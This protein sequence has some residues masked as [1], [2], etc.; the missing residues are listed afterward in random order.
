VIDCCVGLGSNLGDRMGMLT[1]AVERL[2]LEE[3]FALRG[4]SR[5]YETEPVGPPQ[6]RFLNLCVKLGS[7]VS[8]RATLQKLLAIE[9]KLGRV[10]RERWGPREID[11]D[12]LFYGALVS[13]AHGLVPAPHA[14]QIPHPRLHERA[15]VLAPLAELVPELLHPV[16]GK[17]VSRL[18]EDLPEADR[19]SVRAVGRL[20][21]RL[22]FGEDGADEEP[23]PESPG[24][25]A[26]H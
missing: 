2:A 26:S 3:A 5:V 13:P 8:P 4:V 23:P 1:A 10:R 24:G 12:L 18:L 21:R 7:L 19:A 16:L 20:R 14:V 25:P 11:L 15:F 9:E 22:D 6:P 17:T